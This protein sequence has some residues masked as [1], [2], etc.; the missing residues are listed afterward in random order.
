MAPVIQVEHVYKKY[1]RKANEHL[2]YGLGD[3]WALFTGRRPKQG[4]RK[5]EFH[6]VNDI[7]FTLEQG[8]SF[9]LVGRNGSGKSTL[10]KMMNGLIKL[11]AGRI[12]MGGRV[13]ALINLG[14]GFSPALTGRDN[15]YNAAALMGLNR[16][17]TNQRID[18]I[19]AFAE[20]D[21]FIDSPVQTYSSGMKARLGFAVA[22]HLDPQILLIDEILAVGDYAFQNRCFARMQQLK[23]RGVTIVLVSHQHNSVIQLCERALWLH[24]GKAMEIGPSKDVVRNYLSF[25]EQEEAA[26]VAQ[27]REPEKT[28]PA[29]QSKPSKETAPRPQGQHEGLFGPVFADPVKIT[30]PAV[31]FAVDGQDTNT[32][33]VHDDVCV[34]FS[35]SL[36]EH[37][38]DLNVTLKFF[39][40]DGLNLTTIS[41]L[42]GDLLK[43][44]HEGEVCCEVEIPDFDFTPNAYV[45]VIAVHEGKSYLYRDIAKEFAVIGGET[46]TWGIRDFQYVYRV[47]GATVYDTRRSS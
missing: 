26:K 13:Q 33:R 10:L 8:D 36:L 5:D 41:T 44:V 23:K 9:A 42:N 32:L 40:R 45:L 17:Q 21:E 25:L 3:L 39:T 14:A 46:F 7:S 19:V 37:V 16:K 43:P 34:R 11:D 31:I 38:D 28:A 20:L 24:H 6:A 30:K 22:V 12:V 18:D 27:R 47:G 15:I 4:L 2:S 1:S 35:F 29:A